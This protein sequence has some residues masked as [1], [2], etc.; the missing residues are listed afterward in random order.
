V[1]LLVTRCDVG[2]DAM[3]SL[4]HARQMTSL[5]SRGSWDEASKS[6]MRTRTPCYFQFQN[7]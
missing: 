4:R 7:F 1:T 5:V 6:I 2:K 3:L